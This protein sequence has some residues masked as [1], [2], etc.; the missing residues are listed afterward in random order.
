M[1]DTLY[2]LDPAFPD[3]RYPDRTFFCPDCITV[4]GLLRAFPEQA[5]GLTIIRV[6]YARP[7]DVVIAVAGEENQ[8]LPLLVLGDDAPADLADG[9]HNDTR[10]VGD[11][12]RLLHALHVRHGFPE[13]HP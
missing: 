10:F 5:N 2:L 4:D 6:P 9:T 13:A 8:N 7:R 12:K 11:F 3:E 1:T